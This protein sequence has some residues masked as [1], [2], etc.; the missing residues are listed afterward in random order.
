MVWFYVE[1]SNILFYIMVEK[2]VKKHPER[3]FKSRINSSRYTV[4]KLA[5]VT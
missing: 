1:E 2:L 4:Y 5:N 3:K